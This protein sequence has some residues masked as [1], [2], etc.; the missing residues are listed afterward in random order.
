MADSFDCA[1]S[2]LLCAENSDTC[3]DDLN[4][5]TIDDLGLFPSMPHIINNTHNQDPSF[6]HNRSKSMIDFPLQ[7][8]EGVSSMVKRES[9]HFPRD[10]YLK[11]LRNGDL[12]LSSRR[13]A[14]DWISKVGLV[15]FL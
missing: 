10:D 3:F 9:E 1:N 7:S 5:N 15:T 4:S 8:E 12:D 11:R 13:E 6:N 2:N 14:L